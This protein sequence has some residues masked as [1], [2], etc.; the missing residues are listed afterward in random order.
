MPCLFCGYLVDELFGYVQQLLLSPQFDQKFGR[1]H[2]G[3]VRRLAI[4]RHQP[5][6]LYANLYRSSSIVEAPLPSTRA[7]CQQHSDPSIEKGAPFKM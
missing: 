7:D 6:N 2:R 3:H 5:H 1:W 4:E